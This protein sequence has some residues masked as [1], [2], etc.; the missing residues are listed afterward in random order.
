M[1]GLMAGAAFFCYAYLITPV[2]SRV[3]LL[4]STLSH[5]PSLIN[6]LVSSLMPAVLGALLRLRGEGD[7]SNQL[8]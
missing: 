4:L 8:A 7:A 1:L 3:A 2:G 5:S 6:M